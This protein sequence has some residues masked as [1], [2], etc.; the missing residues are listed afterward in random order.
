[1]PTID[2]RSRRPRALLRALT[3]SVLAAALVACS[4]DPSSSR[5]PFGTYTLVR[6]ND[7][8]LPFAITTAEGNMVVQSASLTLSPG[9]ADN[10]TYSASISGTD[11][12]VA[13]VLLVDL[14]QYA[15]TGSTIT[16]T[17]ASGLVYPGTLASDVVTVSVPGAALETSGTIT[18]RFER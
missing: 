11:D 16:F 15:V 6:V 7:Q 2:A 18:M 9:L 8:P 10:P 4:D 5:S 13:G 17:S 3:L 14:G 1:M 12:G